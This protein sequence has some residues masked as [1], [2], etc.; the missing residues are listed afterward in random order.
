MKTILLLLIIAGLL[1]LRYRMGY[2]WKHIFSPTRWKAVYKWF[3]KKELKR[4]APEENSFLLT[5]NE[6]LQVA[7]RVIM[8]EECVQ[9]GKCVKCNCDV[10]GAMSDPNL[11]CSL[12]KW[13]SMKSEEEMNK[14]REN[15]YYDI[16]K[17]QL[18]DGI[19]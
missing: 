9:R 11:S 6:L 16:R 12:A 7:N 5:P 19:F 10:G 13:G 2:E 18:R 1:H 8:C 4:V 17:N 15:N 3:L 14:Y